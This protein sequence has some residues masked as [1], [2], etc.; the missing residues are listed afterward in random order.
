MNY[1]LKRGALFLIGLIILQSCEPLDTGPIHTVTFHSNGGTN[2]APAKVR[3]GESLPKS[4]VYPDP[5][6]SDGGRFLGWYADAELQQ[7]YDFDQPVVADA[8]LYAKWFY[9]TFTIHFVMNGAPEIPAKE[10]REGHL[11]I[12]DAPAY[13]DH[14]F[15]NWYLDE[16]LT[17]LFD[18]TVPI[19]EDLTLYARWVTP[20]PS[21]WFVIDNGTLTM[22]TPPDGTDVVVIPEGV[23]TL[24][25]W[26]VLANGL[27]EP[28]KPGFP[29]GKDIR[30]FILPTSLETI[31]SGAFKFAAIT[32]IH[33]PPKVRQLL[34]VTFEGCDRLTSFTFATGSQLERLVDNASNETIIGAPQLT[35]IS[36]PPSLQYVGKYTLAGCQALATVTFERAE[37]PVVFDGFLPGGGVWLFGGHFPSKIRV[38]NA[39]KEAF[40]SEMRKVMQDYE[41]DNMKAIVE[42]Y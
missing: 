7:P 38:P 17:E 6:V 11:P 27:N 33:I 2:I 30:E 24:P 18:P 10:I 20:S 25:D 4:R 41:Y 22:C 29:T 15:V 23:T 3:H 19:S 42:G 14:V 12:L 26:F 28:G 5:I 31:G 37:S 39:V 21:S 34:P 9:N 8:Q 32:R 13:P 35:Q 40:V 36:F 16:A 1:I